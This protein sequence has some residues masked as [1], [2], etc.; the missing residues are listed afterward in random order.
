MPVVVTGEPETVAL[1]SVPSPVKATE[2]TADAKIGKT[3]APW[4]F[5]NSPVVPVSTRSYLYLVA[6]CYPKKEGITL[7][8]RITGAPSNYY[9]TLIPPVTASAYQIGEVPLDT[10]VTAAPCASSTPDPPVPA[11]DGVFP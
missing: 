3:P 4:D 5:R 2:V 7:L 11:V 1:K 10:S 6:I 8:T 9:V